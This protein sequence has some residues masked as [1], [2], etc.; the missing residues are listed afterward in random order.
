MKASDFDNGRHTAQ[1]LADLAWPAV[2]LLVAAMTAVFLYRPV[3]SLPVLSPKDFNEGY[4][5]YFALNAFSVTGLYPSREG[6]IANGY[7]PLFFYLAGAVGSILG[8]HI[9]AGRAMALLGFAV[10]CAGVGLVVQHVAQDRWAA[11]FTAT[12]FAAFMALHHPSYIA[13]NDPQWMA[14]AFIVSAL[15]LFLK[16]GESLAGLA[17]VVLLVLLA[18]LT[19]Q[20]VIALPLAI[21]ACLLTLRRKRL[22]AWLLLSSAAL[23]VCG[24]A[25]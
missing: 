25:F 13:M 17:V 21:T 19:K 16:R 6:L 11:L 3:M 1:A 9:I 2:L 7:T 5:A 12:F 4:H 22:A 18:G 24:A 15:Y 10:T 23:A 8:D 20:T 14:Q